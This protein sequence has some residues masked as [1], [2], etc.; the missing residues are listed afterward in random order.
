MG[1]ISEMLKKI[2]E[3]ENLYNQVKNL[4][5]QYRGRYKVADLLQ[6][7]YGTVGHIVKGLG[8]HES[9][10]DRQNLKW[11]VIENKDPFVGGDFS[12]YLLGYI[13]GDGCL[14]VKE[15]KVISINVSSSDYEHLSRIRDLWDESLVI[16]GPNKGNYIFNCSDKRQVEKLLS[17]GFAPAKSYRGMVLNFEINWS[18]LRGLFDSDGSISFHNN[19]KSIRIMW[20]GNESYMIKVREF[21]LKEGIKVYETKRK[22]IVIYNVYKYQ[23]I[24]KVRDLMYKNAVIKLQ[25]KYER[26]YQPIKYRI[27]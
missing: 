16:K 5:S 8:L 25:R 1:L 3:D 18:I 19:G 22:S 6:V 26:F 27:N 10:R 17:L 14:Q 7:S 12:D 24:L 23:D 21:L 9:R 4:Y 20:A 13:L 11:Y 15:G 2:Q